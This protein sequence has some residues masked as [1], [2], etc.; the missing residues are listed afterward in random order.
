MMKRTQR[1]FTLIELLVVIL[2]ISI[3]S[4][5]AL[6]TISHN[7]NKTLETVTSQLTQMVSLAEEEALLKPNVFSLSL[8]H[9]ALQFSEYQLA[10]DGNQ[11]QWQPLHDALFS[12]DVIP[13]DVQISMHVGNSTDNQR[14]IISSNGDLTP[15]TIDV[16]EKGNKPRYRI[17]GDADGNVTSQELS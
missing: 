16:G 11:N 1:G 2:I 12:Q 10:A 5:V 15:F 7:K 17:T 14:I 13:D 8:N 3:V 9:H 4:S 6:L